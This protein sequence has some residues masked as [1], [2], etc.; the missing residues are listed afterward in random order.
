MHPP[1]YLLGAHVVAMAPFGECEF[2]FRTS[3]GEPRLVTVVHGGGGVGKTSL[4]QVLAH[5]RPGH[6]AVLLGRTMPGSEVPAHAVCEWALG[7]DDPE[8]P[9]PLTVM[10][11]NVRLADDDAAALRRREQ[12][13]FDRHA[14]ERGGFVFL[15]I[16]AARWF[17]RQPV[18]LH[19]PARTVTNYDVRA[20]ASFD[21]AAHSDLTRETK[22]ALA[23]AGI[24]AAL[25]PSTQRERNALRDRPGKNVDTRLLG[26]AMHETVL[27]LVRLANFG[28][29]GIDPI[30]LE[31]TFITPG[32]RRTLFERLPTRVRHLVAL[33]ALPV[34]TLWAAYPGKDPRTSEGV[35]AIDEI[36]LHLDDAVAER[37]VSV[38]RHALP[39]V[40]WIVTTSS[41]VVAGSVDSREV[42]ALRRL[43]EEEHVELF[44][45]AQA[46]TH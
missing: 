46:R 9:H 23:Y 22:Q 33:A 1:V 5:A 14:K 8:R 27:A 10:T 41:T 7:D 24:S 15:S 37:I 45:G 36:D 42:L 26:S 20:T 3:E 32:G 29:Q 19:A 13:L 44:L 35:V 39:R 28:Y 12:A 40:Q 38:L 11:P 6:A 43:P 2:P 21:D 30:T 34:R 17:S 4:L 16:S 18:S 31:P 25:A